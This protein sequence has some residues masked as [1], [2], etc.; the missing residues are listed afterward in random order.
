[1]ARTKKPDNDDLVIMKFKDWNDWFGK[2]D[3]KQAQDAN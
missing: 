1:M 3:N 2:L